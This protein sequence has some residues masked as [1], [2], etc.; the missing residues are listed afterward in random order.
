MHRE[1]TSRNKSETKTWVASGLYK[2][3]WIS[4]VYRAW[5]SI[6]PSLFQHAPPA[7]WH[8]LARRTFPR[9]LVQYFIQLIWCH[10]YWLK[11]K[12]SFRCIPSAFFVDKEYRHFQRK[13]TAFN[14]RELVRNIFTLLGFFIV[15]HSQV[16]TSRKDVTHRQKNCFSN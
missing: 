7:A 11:N 1:W 2:L 15:K 16:V 12:G 10:P 13:V 14:I 5:S 9:V 3:A 8:L 6:H 4:W